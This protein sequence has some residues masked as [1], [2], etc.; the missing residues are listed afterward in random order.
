[1]Q[2]LR[3]TC[4]IRN[5]IRNKPVKAITIFLPIA[6]VKKKDHFI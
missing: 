4:T 5:V 1:M 2:A 6:V 3:P